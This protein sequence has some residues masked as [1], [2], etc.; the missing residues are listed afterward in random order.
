ME[1]GTFDVRI[2][3]QCFLLYL[4]EVIGTMFLVLAINFLDHHPLYVGC[5]I[6]M[7]VMVAG[8]RTGGHFNFGVTMGVYMM[9]R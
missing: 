1:D 9:K 7:G 3:S 6:F 4:F 8:R 5:G 2:P